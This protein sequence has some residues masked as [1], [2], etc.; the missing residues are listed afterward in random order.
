MTESDV[1][2]KLVKIEN[3]AET[4]L[5][6]I[7][8]L[9]SQKFDLVQGKYYQQQYSEIALNYI[10]VHFLMCL[11][12]Y[13]E[14]HEVQQ[15]N[16]DMEDKLAD[17]AHFQTEQVSSEIKSVQLEEQIDQLSASMKELELVVENLK[18]NK[19]QLE[20][21]IKSLEEEKTQL[22]HKLENF[23]QE[24]MELT[25]KL[26][27]LSADKV[28]SAESIEIVESLTTQ[29]KL[30][31]EEY[32]KG[33]TDKIEETP[34]E[35]HVTPECQENIE[36]LVEQS[37][38]LNSKIEL[39]T[40]ERQEVMEK[41][42]KISSE[43]DLL[44]DK[45]TELDSQ[46]NSLQNTIE[47]LSNE[48]QEILKLN[49][50][51]NQQIE[52]LK[53]ERVEIM[54]ESVELPKPASMDEGPE[55]MS[56][57][58]QQDDKIA[59][60]KG[61]NRTKSVKQLT[62]E[63]LKLK[64]IIKE[65]EEEIG[66]CQMKIL[67]LEEQQQKHNELMQMNS[68]YE[69]KL[70]S[71]SDENHKLKQ[72]LENSKVN[73][74]SEQHFKQT[75]QMLQQEMQRLH[76]DYSTTINSR[77]ARINELENALMEYEK[78]IYNYGNTLQQKD[79][80]LAEYINQITKLNDVSQKLKSTIEVLE[81][82]KSK[83]PNGELVKT[84]NKQITAHQKKLSEYEDKLRSLEEEKS[85]LLN[86]K[87][88]LE[89]TNHTIETELKT[90]QELYL[91]KQS[92]IKELQSQQQKHSEEISNVMSQLKE[93]DE[94]V[95]EVKLQLRKESIENEKLRT[96][97]SE[98]DNHSQEFTQEFE[99]AREEVSKLTLENQQSKEQYTIV[100]TKNKALMEKLKKFAAS[101]KKKSS[102][103]SELEGELNETH[104]QLEVKN[105][106][107]EQLTIQV[108]TLPALQD[109]L[110]HAAEELNRLQAQKIALEESITRVENELLTLNES[111]SALQHEANRSQ[112]ENLHLK[113]QI[114][115][116]NNK[117]AD[118]EV[119]QKNNTN[120]VTKMSSLEGELN[121]KQ[122]HIAELLN[123]LE[124]LEQQLTQ[125]RF[126]HDA[127]VQERDLYIE[128]LETEIS[129]F[130]NRICR[131][132][133]SISIMED[134]RKTLERKADQLDSQLQEKQKAYTEYTS[135]EDQ[136]VSRLAV[137]MDHDRV[138]EKQ[139][140]EIEND[141]KE[142]QYKTQHFNE[143]NQ[144]LRR[145]LSDIQEHCHTLEE[146]AS[147][148]DSAEAELVKYKSQLHELDA[149]LKRM[150][151][152]HQTLFAQK[153][154]DIEE[155]ELEFNTQI[156][157]AIREK[158][159]LSEK[160]EKVIEHVTQ[161]EHRLHDYRNNNETLKINIEELARMNHELIEK[162]H[163][164]QSPI[165][166][167]TE[168]YI[169][170]IN[171]LNSI[172]NSKNQEIHELNVKS[173][174]LQTH[175]LTLTSN[176]ETKINELNAQ[177]MHSAS[178]IQRLSEESNSMK[179][180][181]EQL[182]T[183]LSQKDNQIK[184]LREKKTVSFEMSIPKTEGLVISSTIEPLSDASKELDISSLESQ[185]VSGIE[186]IDAGK[187]HASSKTS[188]QIQQQS[189]GNDIPEE[190]SEP[191]V[192]AKKAYLCYKGEE[193]EAEPSD[194]PFNS[195]EGWGFGEGEELGEVTPGM[196]LMTSQLHHLQKDNEAL[197]ADL[198][199]SNNKLLKA[200][201]KLKELKCSNDMLLNELKVSKQVSESS[202]LE[203]AIEEELKINVQDLENKVKELTTDLN[204][205]KREKESLRK[206][207]EVL[208]SAN[209]RLTEIKEKLDNDIELWKFK[210]KE[211]NDKMSA[212]QWSSDSKDSPVHKTSAP[213]NDSVL[214]EEIVKLEKENDE[215]QS[216]ID[217]MTLQNKLLINQQ[218]QLESKINDLVHQLEQ[219]KSSGDFDDISGKLEEVQKSNTELLSSRD[220]LNE[221]LR[222]IE[223]CYNEVTQN[224]DH[225]TTENGELR[226]ALESKTKHLLD[227]ENKFKEDVMKLQ[228]S[229]T[230]AMSQLS[231]L[232]S[233]LESTQ[234]K[235][236]W[237][238]E[239][240]SVRHSMEEDP[241]VVSEKYSAMEDN[242][243]QLRHGLDQANRKMSVL[244]TE[245]RDLLQKINQYEQQVT[246][247][248]TKIQH[249]NTENDQL[250]C[251]V[252]ELRSS[253]SSAVDQRG[254]EIAELWKHHLAQRESDFQNID[255]ELRAQLSAFE[256]KYE[257]LLDSVQSSSQEETNKLVIM[258]QM[259]SLQN[260]LQDKEEHL[261]NLQ[262]KYAEVI[263][264]IDMLRSEMEDEKLMYENK[265]LGQQEEYEKQI[266]ALTASTK[267]HSEDY[268]EVYAK[269]QIELSA[270]KASNDELNQQME[271]IRGKVSECEER[272]LDLTNQLRMK[273]GEINQKTHDYTI[274]LNQRNE[275]FENVRKQL[276]EYEKNIEDLNYEKESELAVMRLKMHEKGQHYEKLQVDLDAEKLNLTEALNAK[277][278]ECSSLNKQITD[279][280]KMLEEQA[281]STTDMQ[282]ALEN[283]ELEIVTLKDEITNLL[284]NKIEKHVTFASGTKPGEGENAAGN[285]LSRDLLDA[286]PRAELD[287][288]LYML[289]Q[290]DVRCEELTME[291]TQLLEERD[292]LQ[293]RLSDSLRS[294]EELKAR[295]QSGG[296]EVPAGP[297]RE[298]PP[299]LPTFAAEK[300]FV[301]THRGQ[302]SRSGS[303][304]DAD[305]EKPKLQAK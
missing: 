22:M 237:L 159:A 209:D 222:A 246:E 63:I 304:G 156:E 173:R 242:C 165:P 76:Q 153:K 216:N 110:K 182:K 120:Y 9:E 152:E 51:L 116:L 252:A 227:I 82:E 6:A 147:K 206:Q 251:T 177:L 210:F 138:V 85:Q 94:E 12:F 164:E 57:E 241:M 70:K 266:L 17:V 169:S 108:E 166:D 46:C 151:Q 55:G 53:R 133:E 67:A 282:S 95:H 298:G 226:D 35:L 26:E 261:H 286:V 262:D 245:N 256:A 203:T 179:I 142:L 199:V 200:L 276:L 150:T 14:L 16:A 109:K 229:E 141:N 39:F 197:K 68:M 189:A 1:Y 305:G 155:I 233:E 8:V 132:E 283:Q 279:L 240:H 299:E 32:N 190:V 248:N 102:M 255:Q 221:K 238:Q 288:A 176:L 188:E 265:L 2:K 98:K 125:V 191:M 25:D 217:Q 83:D 93:R 64:N 131:L 38:E 235:L 228:Q 239:R 106:Q 81:E 15:K 167:Y 122:S 78:Q 136:L 145:S 79:K 31:L 43:N 180:H 48:K 5:K 73:S 258:E 97:L 126:G 293:L 52:E 264:Q 137:L 20:G 215:L 42:G 284:K 92:L 290:R 19:G 271:Q 111:Y 104:K 37:A 123:K 223:K 103:Y 71:L 45:I 281:N 118:Y 90:L 128:S 148:T 187:K 21:S 10:F 280:N 253:V 129:K 291:L 61:N 158:K 186:E 302:T 96:S 7:S 168:Q 74:E 28:S 172:I 62:K 214:N 107:I 274:A 202:F 254:F 49:E 23:I 130:R 101:V 301:D 201:K 218:E 47:L 127:K 162:S 124:Y 77:D 69:S 231:L 54:K 80:D 263:G 270:A 249:L 273:D 260:K 72:E 58:A 84:L 160:Y 259:S 112:D 220:A 183:L 178:A 139:L 230:E 195:E 196:S 146:K 75:Q 175:T 193:T 285:V 121:L 247:L 87:T 50:E 44:H 60:E 36:K 154:H 204:K 192:V 275:E 29:E 161:L 269:L 278:V 224:Y 105:A 65:R 208:G 41:M 297:T 287:L 66:D 144:R 163:R 27:K 59:G 234:S 185:I 24:N 272:I 211:A 303:I 219:S 117:L 34:S 198:D 257:Q 33:M 184:Q 13:T 100:D 292:T 232:A 250:L 207:T 115:C 18:L 56:S 289:H 171:N 114:E 268:K 30:E 11:S 181:I 277:I 267:Q 99:R 244:E 86:R 89:S 149:H 134:R 119:E 4:R 88:A 295:C 296:I 243:S 212:L 294:F 140:H 225:L 213:V 157:N 205:E 91:E 135:Q 174:S 300:E 143:E 3:L 40:Q 113:T 236:L 170:E 194:D